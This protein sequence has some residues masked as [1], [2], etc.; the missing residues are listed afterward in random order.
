MTIIESTAKKNTSTETNISEPIQSTKA[1]EEVIVT[2]ETDTDTSETKQD[3]NQVL[4]KTETRT[5]YVNIDGTE[6]EKIKNETTL[7]AVVKDRIISYFNNSNNLNTEATEDQPPADDEVTKGEY[8]KVEVDDIVIPEKPKETE[9]LQPPS[10]TKA[11]ETYKLLPKVLQDFLNN[12]W[13]TKPKCEPQRMLERIRNEK[14]Y[15][16]HADTDKYRLL[17]TPAPSFLQRISLAGE[18]LSKK[19]L[20]M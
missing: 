12:E 6:R 15:P 19:Q 20:E 2:N 9:A 17:L 18:F 7:R 8:A 5:G 10:V 1:E 16:D 4:I 14:L 3:R 13:K 11:K